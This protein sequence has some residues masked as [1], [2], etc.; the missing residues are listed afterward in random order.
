VSIR[1]LEQAA[2]LAEGVI[3]GVLVHYPGYKREHPGGRA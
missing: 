2:L 3:G 1:N